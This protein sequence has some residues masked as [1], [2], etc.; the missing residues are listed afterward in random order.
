MKWLV[1]RGEELCRI[2]KVMCNAF[3]YIIIGTRHGIQKF[4]HKSKLFSNSKRC[5][6]LEAMLHRYTEAIRIAECG[7]YG[8][9]VG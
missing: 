3:F 6:G 8:R 5:M 4:N 2:P 1:I 9:L 7:C